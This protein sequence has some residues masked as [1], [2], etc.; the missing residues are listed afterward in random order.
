ML[1]VRLVDAAADSKLEPEI[2]SQVDDVERLEG[3]SPQLYLRNKKEYKIFKQFCYV[4]LR[5]ARILL[6]S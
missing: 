2:K 5:K 1:L 6:M 4:E 3:W